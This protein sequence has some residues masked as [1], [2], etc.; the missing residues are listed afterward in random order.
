MFYYPKS[1]CRCQVQIC[2]EFLHFSRRYG[3]WAQHII[4]T[5]V[6]ATVFETVCHFRTQVS[7]I[8]TQFLQTVFST[9]HYMILLCP[10]PFVRSVV[11]NTE[12][13]IYV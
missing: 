8:A 13:Q 3:D 4:H 7:A 6:K 2:L 9:V 10:I 11:I 5:L 12:T 1:F